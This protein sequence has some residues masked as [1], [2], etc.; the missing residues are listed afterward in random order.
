MLPP[1][2][3]TMRW[4]RTVCGRSYGPGYRAGPARTSRIHRT[5]GFQYW[6]RGPMD[7]CMA[8]TKRLRI[9]H[10]GAHESRRQ[11]PGGR[12]YPDSSARTMPASASD[13]RPEV[14]LVHLW[15]RWIAGLLGTRE[16]APSHTVKAPRTHPNQPGPGP[17]GEEQGRDRATSTPR[18]VAVQG[19]GDPSKAFRSLSPRSCAH[20]V[21]PRRHWAS[22]CR[23]S[24][25]CPFRH[26]SNAAG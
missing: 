20:G 18:A 8:A 9:D 13:K 19:L 22:T 16:K 12:R 14:T 4:P 15:S 11:R 17:I 5:Q 21:K 7:G 3:P 6:I 24:I 1:A 2:V 10:R 26:A 23:E 25:L